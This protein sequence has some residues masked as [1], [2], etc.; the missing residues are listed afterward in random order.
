MTPYLQSEAKL[1]LYVDL[2][3]GLKWI[4]LLVPF[5]ISILREA[6]SSE[7]SLDTHHYVMNTGYN[8]FS[9]FVYA[10]CSLLRCS[11]PH[12]GWLQGGEGETIV[13]QMQAYLAGDYLSPRL[14][15]G[16]LKRKYTFLNT[17][18]LTW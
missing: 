15:R 12:G 10:F 4:E 13:T 16:I 3:K 6:G 14:I 17:S 7:V 18:S 1:Y 11:V 9:I 5:L 2:D 8:A